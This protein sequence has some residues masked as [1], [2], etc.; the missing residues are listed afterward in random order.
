MIRLRLSELESRLGQRHQ[1]AMAYG[2]GAKCSEFTSAFGG[3]VDMAGLTTGSTRSRMTQTG[4]VS[5][6]ALQAAPSN[7]AYRNDPSRR[8]S[9]LPCANTPRL[10]TKTSERGATLWQAERAIDRL[11]RGEVQCEAA[12]VH[13]AA[14]RSSGQ[15]R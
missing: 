15:R 14:P 1:P 9:P 12:R 2:V 3:M 8:A 7:P 13:Q 11:W 10:A 5:F 4:Q 6:V